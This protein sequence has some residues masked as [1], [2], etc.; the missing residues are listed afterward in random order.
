MFI[1]LFCSLRSK[2]IAEISEQFQA[3]LFVYDEG[4]L[5]ND[6]QLANALWR[7]FFLSMREV[8]EGSGEE[9]MPD[10]EKLELLVRYVRRTASYL[11]SKDAA[12]IIVRQQVSWPKVLDV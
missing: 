1:K 6:I 5:G 12:D 4:I 2:Y 11:D 9:H 8:E 10:P 7:R 3:S